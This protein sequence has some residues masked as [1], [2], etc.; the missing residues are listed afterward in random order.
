MSLRK[1]RLIEYASIGI[2]AYIHHVNA[3]QGTGYS[4]KELFTPEPNVS[5][6]THPPTGVMLI[7]MAL[8]LVG[9]WTFFFNK[10]ES[11]SSL[12]QNTFSIKKELALIT[13]QDII[14]MLKII[15]LTTIVMI[16]G[17]FIIWHASNQA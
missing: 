13:R 5:I 9:C 14:I 15:L 16:I 2:L 8:T 12:P 11:K 6:L 4:W 7:V 1:F 3:K 17:V 10:L